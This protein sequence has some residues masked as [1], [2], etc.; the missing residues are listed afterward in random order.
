MLFCNIEYIEIHVI[1]S[2]RKEKK[3][4]EASNSTQY[5]AVES[6][7]TQQVVYKSTKNMYIQI[8]Y[9]SLANV[10]VMC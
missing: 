9:Q 8:C 1:K 2:K 10:I 5:Q 6:Q 4:K 3:G 7:K